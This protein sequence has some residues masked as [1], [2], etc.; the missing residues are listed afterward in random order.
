MRPGLPPFRF[1][2]R[3]KGKA[4]VSDIMGQLTGNG[5]ARQYAPDGLPGDLPPVEPPSAGFIVQLFVIPAAIVAVVVVVWLLFGKLAGGERDAM[6][7]VQTIKDANENRRWRAAFELGTLI[8]ND[9]RL[10]RDPALLG[11]LTDL[12]TAELA[13]PQGDEKTKQYLAASL[14]TFRTL[15]AQAP[16]AA[17]KA[18]PIAA[19]TAALSADQPLSVRMAA[20]ESLAR[21]AARLDES[22]DDEAAVRA[23]SEA[24]K[25]DDPDLRQRATFA[26]GFFGGTPA[27]QA[28]RRRLGSDDAFVRY[29]AAVHLARRGDVLAKPVVQEMLSPKDLRAAVRR[30]NP[31]QES[32]K[33]EAFEL[34]IL[35]A[36]EVS[37]RQG[38]PELAREVQPAVVEQGRS[39]LAGVRTQADAVLK[40][41][42]ARP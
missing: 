25:E 10:A 15:E 7:Y 31:S 18:D 14:G 9:N 6:D 26:L 5:E 19:L 1:G 2:S 20:A 24:G 40:S 12:L 34:E 36:L 41:L 3:T 16:G 33:V 38:H 35:K 22:L 11:A 4:K 8:H 23:L 37:I 28:L 30:A 27:V 32:A 42:P 29:A 39:G 13:K 17:R 21:Q